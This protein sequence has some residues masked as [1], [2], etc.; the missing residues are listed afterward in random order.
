MAGSAHVLEAINLKKKKNNIMRTA[1]TGGSVCVVGSR[2][3]VTAVAI[4]TIC[5]F[6]RTPQP[7]VKA[8]DERLRCA[9]AK[10]TDET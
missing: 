4:I 7:V 1:L 8:I 6:A 3:L 5:G 2:T 10:F 9:V